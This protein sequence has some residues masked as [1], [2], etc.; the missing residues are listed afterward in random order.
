[1]KL[2][3]MSADAIDPKLESSLVTLRRPLAD[4]A[5]DGSQLAVL[6]AAA[7]PVDI[8]LSTAELDA[9]GKGGCYKDIKAAATN[10]LEQ[11]DKF[12]PG[13]IRGL[14]YTMRFLPSTPPVRMPPLGPDEQHMPDSVRA[15]FGNMR[16]TTKRT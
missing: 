8:A 3:L 10:A 16:V 4:A 5:S 13:I 2:T 11:Y 14:K 1:M 12:I 15:F 9:I 7:K 6:V